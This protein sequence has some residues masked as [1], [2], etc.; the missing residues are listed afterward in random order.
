MS[1]LPAL[2]LAPLPPTAMTQSELRHEVAERRRQNGPLEAENARL[3]ERVAFLSE[4][5][6]RLWAS[7]A[8][9]HDHSGPYAAAMCWSDQR[10]PY[11]D[12]Y[13]ETMRAVADTLGQDMPEWLR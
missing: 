12:A 3:R 11:V 5:L 6:A 4:Q 9:L 1:T 7:S 10:Q 8:P 13:L 2:I